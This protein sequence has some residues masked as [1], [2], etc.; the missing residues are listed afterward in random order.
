M[1]VPLRSRPRASS[2]LF[3]YVAAVFRLARAPKAKAEGMAEGERATR[4]AP[5]SPEQPKPALR[6]P[7]AP[8][9]IPLLAAPLSRLPD[10]RLLFLLLLLLL[11]LPP[12]PISLS[13]RPPKGSQVSQGFQ[14]PAPKPQL[15]QI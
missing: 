4:F 7:S 12:L 10:S 13:P 3:M 15:P 6:P 1:G 9:A 11:L 5:G 8:L 14:A 2:R